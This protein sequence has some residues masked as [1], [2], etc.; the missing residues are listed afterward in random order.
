MVEA[1]KSVFE[2]AF[3]ACVDS[4]HI[5]DVEDM[6]NSLAFKDIISGENMI[7]KYKQWLRKS[8]YVEKTKTS[9][10]N[11][12]KGTDRVHR[13]LYFKDRSGRTDEQNQGG[14]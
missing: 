14:L 1:T 2:L 13:C 8:K 12:Y 3:D 6:L 5:C 7:E 10:L 9:S 11:Y 4:L